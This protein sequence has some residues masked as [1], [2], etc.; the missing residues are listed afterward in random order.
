MI[1]A[2]EAA[3]AVRGFVTAV[4]VLTGLGW[5]APLSE[6]AWRQ[7]RIPYLERVMSANL[8][9]ISRAMRHFRRW[10]HSRGLKPSETAY[11]ARTRDRRTL[12]FSNSGKPSVELAYRTHW[13]SPRLSE[14]RRERVAAALPKG[15]L[16]WL[17]GLGHVAHTAAPDVVAAEVRGLL[18]GVDQ[19]S[20]PKSSSSASGRT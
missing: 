6:R 1:D 15:R 19:P 7:G 18:E 13:V 12:R 2:A 14:R 4:D 10:A 16:A 11:V 20:H 9:K 3:L 8:N 5:L 17:D